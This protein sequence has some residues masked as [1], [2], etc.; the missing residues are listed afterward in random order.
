MVTILSFPIPN[1][2]Y[3]FPKNKLLKGKVSIMK[4]SIKSQLLLNNSEL[5]I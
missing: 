2:N 4:L 5:K 1:M 3:L